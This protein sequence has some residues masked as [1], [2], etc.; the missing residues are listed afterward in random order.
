MPRNTEL[1]SWRYSQKQTKFCRTWEKS[2]S[3]TLR[4]SVDVQRDVL[5]QHKYDTVLEIE[6]LHVMN[7]GNQDLKCA[8]HTHHMNPPELS[9]SFRLKMKGSECNVTFVFLLWSELVLIDNV[10]WTFQKFPSVKPVFECNE[11]QLLYMYQKDGAISCK[12]H[13]IPP[14]DKFTWWAFLAFWSVSIS[15]C[16][17]DFVWHDIFRKMLLL[18]CRNKW[19]SKIFE[20]D[21]LLTSA[22]QG[23]RVICS[24]IQSLVVLSCRYTYYG[25]NMTDTYKIVMKPGDRQGAYRARTRIVSAGLSQLPGYRHGNCNTPH[26]SLFSYKRFLLI[27]RSFRGRHDQLGQVCLEGPEL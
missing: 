27:L 3:L 8:A 12:V 4:W 5:L 18:R 13:G 1:A 20:C 14:P 19:T 9:K 22:R 25:D 15:V 6:S 21:M 2:I 11:T 16:L 23:S 24:R 10:V 17:S 26:W 7:Y